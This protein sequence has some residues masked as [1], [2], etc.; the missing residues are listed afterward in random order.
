M[1][2]PRTQASRGGYT[3]IELLVAAAVLFVIVAY[4][5]ASFTYQHQTYVVV[6]QLSETQQNNRAIASLIE[7]DVRN[8]GYMVPSAAAG[9][10]VD[11]DDAPDVLY[12]TDAD[13]IR[14]I[15]EL[16]ASM[17][18]D[19]LSASVVTVTAGT[20]DLVRV[21]DV[22][23]DAQATYDTNA[24]GTPDSDFQVNGGAILVDVANPDRGA[25]CGSVTAVTLG[26]SPIVSVNLMQ[27]DFGA[28]ATLPAELVLVPAHVYSISAGPPPELRRNGE[29]MAKDIEDMQVAWFF[30]DGDGQVDANEY[31]GE[32]GN[33][34]DPTALD[35]NN[36]REIR[37]SLVARTRSDDPRNPDNAGTGQSIENRD[38]NVAGDDGRRRRVLTA[39][40]RLRNI[41][42]F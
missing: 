35:A 34:Y 16:G 42:A 23:V 10:G 6:D 26:G 40:V 38:T 28:A 24:D 31:F 39:T 15:D 8:A 12:V 37:V 29:L 22:V 36:L 2:T 13:A 25:R 27:N 41:K 21:D 33:D 5:L 32:D 30:D 14:N 18:S 3:M 1:L 4:A 7:R 9:C 11:A 19:T 17:M 20:P